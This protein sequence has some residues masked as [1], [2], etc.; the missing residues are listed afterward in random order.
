MRHSSS[1]VGLPIA[2]Q[3]YGSVSASICV[4]VCVLERM[5]QCENRERKCEQLKARSTAT[6]GRMRNDNRIFS[7]NV[8]ALIENQSAIA[9]CV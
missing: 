8:L 2:H 1:S 6:N 7:K 3:G 4:C 9:A 5:C